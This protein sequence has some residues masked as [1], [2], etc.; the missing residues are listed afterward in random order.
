M[1][2][3]AEPGT[4]GVD[5]TV[6]YADEVWFVLP[7]HVRARSLDTPVTRNPQFW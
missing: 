6:E 1:Y 3:V 7:I 2:L 4:G 5:G